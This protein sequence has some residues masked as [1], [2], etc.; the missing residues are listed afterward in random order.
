MRILPVLLLM[1]VFGVILC[2]CTAPSVPAPQPAATAYQP[3]QTSAV[4]VQNGPVKAIDII[5][6]SF[7]PQVLS[8][9]QGTTVVWTNR[10]P[11]VHRVVHMPQ[12]PSEKELFNS[13]PMYPKDTF[14]YTF[15]RPGEYYYDDPQLGTGTGTP[16]IIVQ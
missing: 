9:S 7:D 2:G 3:A 10:D 1:I 5:Q 14:S 8:V 6:R 11:T 15:T 4:P 12:V 16:K 13:G